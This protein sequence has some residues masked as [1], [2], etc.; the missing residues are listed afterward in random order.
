MPTSILFYGNC[1][2]GALRQML[3]LDPVL[4]STNYIA[5]HSTKMDKSCFTSLIKTSD[6]IVTQPIRDNYRNHDYLH[7]DYVINNA[8]N[9]K[10]IIFSVCYF[11]F[12]YPDLKYKTHQNTPLNKPVA[13]HYQYMIDNYKNNGSIDDYINNYVNNHQLISKESLLERANNSLNELKQR[14]QSM[15]DKFTKPNMHIICLADFIEKNYKDKLLFYSV[16]H[17]TKYVIQHMCEQIIPILG[18]TNRIKYDID[19]LNVTKCILYKC[20]QP[21]VHFNINDHPVKTVGLTDVVSITKLYYD[22]Y[23]RI[24][25]A[26]K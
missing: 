17:P 12:Y 10:I 11:D 4:F 18:I 25:F 9:C 19:P 3:N 2:I 16:N 14:D 1:Q 15:K 24:D 20:I 22:T 13:Y 5:C 23:R 7:T 8:P 21:V 6:I 26:D